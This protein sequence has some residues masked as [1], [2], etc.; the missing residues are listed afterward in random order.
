MKKKILQA[1]KTF[2]GY[3]LASDKW[4]HL[5]VGFCIASLIG[6]FTP[7][8]GFCTAL[9]VGALKEIYDKTTGKGTPELW[10]FIF[11]ALGAFL[12]LIDTWL[13]TLSINL[14]N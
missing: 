8:G 14:I 3:L 9:V 12:A 13:H 11:T 6:L 4:L 10:D 5:A 1:F 7:I 2:V